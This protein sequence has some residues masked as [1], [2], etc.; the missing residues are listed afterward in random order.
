LVSDSVLNNEIAT[1]VIIFII[2]ISYCF[3]YFIGVIDFRINDICSYVFILEMGIKLVAL[4]PAGYL[5]DKINILDGVIVIM[6]ILELGFFCLFIVILSSFN[7]K[8][9]RTIRIIRSVRVI[10]ISKLLRSL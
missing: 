7:L 4:T 8:S 9:F 1:Y 6:A 2:F 3:C 10:R 5:R